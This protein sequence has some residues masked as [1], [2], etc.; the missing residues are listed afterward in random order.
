MGTHYFDWHH[1]EADTL[2]KV[3][4]DDFRKNVAS[5]AVMSFA[6]ADMPERVVASSGRPRK[7]RTVRRGVC[8]FRSN[9]YAASSG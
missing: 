6:L 8:P 4:I 2:D 1:T 5:L 9:S 3:N 7:T